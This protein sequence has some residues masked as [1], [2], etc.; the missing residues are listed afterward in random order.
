[1]GRLSWLAWLAASAHAAREQCNSEP[2]SSETQSWCTQNCVQLLAFVRMRMPYTSIDF[3]VLRA[4]NEMNTWSVCPAAFRSIVFS[5]LAHEVDQ[6]EPDAAGRR[7]A[8][9][10]IKVAEHAAREFV[11]RNI[12][13]YLASGTSFAPWFHL[14]L[15]FRALEAKFPELLPKRS[16]V[17]SALRASLARHL[18][19]DLAGAGGWA[20]SREESQSSLER[21]IRRLAEADDLRVDKAYGI[22]GSGGLMGPAREEMD[23]LLDSGQRFLLQAYR[24]TKAQAPVGET[25]LHGLFKMLGR[26]GPPLLELLDRLDSQVLEPI[27]MPSSPSFGQ[28]QFRV[29]LLPTR[30]VESNHVRAFFELHCD[31]VFKDLVEEHRHVERPMLVEIGTHLGGCILHALAQLP[32]SRALAVDAYGPAVAALQ[33]TAEQNGLADRLTVV[34]RFI[35]PDDR[36]FKVELNATGPTLLQPTWAEVDSAAGASEGADGSEGVEVSCTGLETV[37]REHQVTDVDLLRIHVLGREY[38]ALRS[39]ESFFARGKIRTV[40]ASVSQ[41]NTEPGSMAA[42]LHRHGYQ[43]RFREFRDEDVVTILKDQVGFRPTPKRPRQL[44]FFFSSPDFPWTPAQKREFAF[45][46]PSR[47]Q[48]FRELQRPAQVVLPK[49]TQTMVAQHVR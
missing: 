17:S 47:R 16:V 39:G 30:N 37:F 20:S 43:L 8:E 13:R 9:H 5:R 4:A 44:S 27:Y 3:N 11:T 33:R 29:H 26:D 28:V 46:F 48:G 18:A 12:S 31:A 41:L 22:P 10:D 38:D 40:A 35:C 7:Q 45:G 15:L 42:M 36:K 2:R 49:S 34:E 25:E 32:S 19:S 21:A 24:Q 6:L 1:M 23:R 14:G